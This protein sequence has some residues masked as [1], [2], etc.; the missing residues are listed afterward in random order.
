QSGQTVAAFEAHIQRNDG[1]RFEAMMSATPL[2]NDNGKSRGAIAAI[3]DITERRAAEAHQQILLHELQHR[4]KNIIT[5]IGALASRMI[6]D[7]ES[8][9]D[10]S[11]A[12]LGRLRAMAA[13]HE[14]LSRGN[15]T[16]AS[17]QALAGAALQ[18]HL[19]K[20]GR[21]TDMR[22]PELLLTPNTAATL[23]L[24]FYEL[25]TN[26]TK[27]GSLSADGRVEIAWRVEP[28]PAGDHAVVEWVEA[29]GPALD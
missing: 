16:G 10:F 4:V 26:A 12:F 2:L 8:L 25:A 11:H 9:E 20:D 3:L 29:G 6:K 22:G 19:G 7:S 1:T 15:W 17:L 14:L 28:T 13:T 27:Y 18:T 24:V 23:G 21:P 5:T